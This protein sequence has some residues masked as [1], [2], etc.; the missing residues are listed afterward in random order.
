MSGGGVGGIGIECKIVF[1]Y[2]N[3]SFIYTVQLKLV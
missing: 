1:V 3:L 2:M